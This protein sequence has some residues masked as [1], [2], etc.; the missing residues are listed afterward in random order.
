MVQWLSGWV[1][2]RIEGDSMP[3][4]LASILRG[5]L[6]VTKWLATHSRDRI[7]ERFPFTKDPMVCAA[8]G[9]HLNILQWLR[10]Q[11][12]AWNAQ[13]C[14][15]AACNGHLGVLKWLREE[16]CPWDETTCQGAAGGD[17]LTVVE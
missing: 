15:G 3:I 5:H 1:D 6:E 13:V 12:A 16:G 4:F 7:E 9:G 17:H 11:R 14:F 10:E 2:T 8:V